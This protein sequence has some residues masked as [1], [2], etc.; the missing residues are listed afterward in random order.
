[1]SMNKVN[2]DLDKLYT[3][4]E[5]ADLLK[6]S[7]VSVF[8]WIKGKRLPAQQIGKTYAIK[9]MDLNEYLSPSDELTEAKKL[10][11]ENI[12]KKVVKEYGEALK[13]LEE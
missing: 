1:M 8:K 2:I 7:R 13:K 10:V 6:V 3:T 5:I 11:I 12:V 9:G 4:K